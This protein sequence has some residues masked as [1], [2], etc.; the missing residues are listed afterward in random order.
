MNIKEFN[1]LLEKFHNNV[2]ENKDCTEV[3]QQ[4]INTQIESFSLI[5]IE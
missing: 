1:M 3:V 4:I 5:T 2:A